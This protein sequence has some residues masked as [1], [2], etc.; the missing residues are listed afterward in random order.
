MFE[1]NFELDPTYGYHECVSVAEGE[2]VIF[3]CPICKDYERR[4]NM[5]T[6]ETKVKDLSPIVRHSGRHTPLPL[7]TLSA[8]PELN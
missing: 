4:I 5:L 6:G 2:W 7:T 1:L 3:R 8:A